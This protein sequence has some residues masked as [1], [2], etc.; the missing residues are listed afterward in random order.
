MTRP[1]DQLAPG[2][3]LRLARGRDQAA[4]NEIVR[5]YGPVVWRVAM[6]QRLDPADAKDVSQNTWFALAERLDRIREPERLAAWL[7]TTARREALRVHDL[8]RLEARPSWWPDDLEDPDAECWPEPHVLRSTRDRLLWRAFA[9]L[10][11]R[12]R[13]LLGLLAHAPDLSYAQ[14]GR[15]L[16]M[17]AGSVGPARG[18]CLYELRRRLAVLGYGEETVG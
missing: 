5:R 11:D 1:Y 18:R 14:L 8:R 16:G 4:W 12:C 9:E 6:A 3:L 10:P 17:K 15:A 13:R 7:A 2:E